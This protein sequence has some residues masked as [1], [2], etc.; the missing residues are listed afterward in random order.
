MGVLHQSERQSS[1]RQ[2]S[3][4][5]LSK[6]KESKGEEES[7]PGSGAQRIIRNVSIIFD[8]QLHKAQNPYRPGIIHAAD[9]EEAES[10]VGFHI[11]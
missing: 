5:K 4:S 6:Q 9:K 1:K 2:S 8:V 7:I 3:E 10:E 11:L